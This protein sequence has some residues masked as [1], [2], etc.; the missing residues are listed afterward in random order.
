LAVIFYF[1][2]SIKTVKLQKMKN[3]KIIISIIYIEL[4]K[5]H[6]IFKK[7]KK[8]KKKKKNKKKKK[9]KKD[10]IKLKFYYILKFILFLIYIFI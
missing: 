2:I 9:K 10:I 8:K 7:K 3:R 1:L 4:I 6:N 5:K